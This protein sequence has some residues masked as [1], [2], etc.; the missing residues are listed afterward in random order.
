MKKK[1][2]CPEAPRRVLIQGGGSF[3]HREKQTPITSKRTT[4][5]ITAVR[6]SSRESR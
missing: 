5:S 3:F 2:D 6:G 1:S 4:G